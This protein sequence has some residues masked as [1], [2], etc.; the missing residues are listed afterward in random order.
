MMANCG[1][2]SS[3]TVRCLRLYSNTRVSQEA[4]KSPSMA[5][6]LTVS[7]YHCRYSPPLSLLVSPTAAYGISKTPSPAYS[8]YHYCHY[9]LLQSSI[10]LVNSVHN[11][12]IKPPICLLKAPGSISA[13]SKLC[14]STF[15]LRTKSITYSLPNLQAAETMNLFFDRFSPPVETSD[16]SSPRH[17]RKCIERQSEAIEPH[18]AELYRSYV[19]KF[20]LGVQVRCQL[21]SC[22]AAPYSE[23]FSR[24]DPSND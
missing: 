11:S 2:L 16:A 22:G 1:S 15:A 4:P 8:Q 13:L 6:S 20:W 24:C 12:Q 7:V 14:H 9:V 18:G 10:P 17:L 23:Q 5:L 19:R 21:R 3:W